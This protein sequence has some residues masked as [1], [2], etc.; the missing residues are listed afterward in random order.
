LE[1]QMSFEAMTWAVKQ[2]TANA[3]QKLVLL[4]LANHA[5]GH[6]GQCNPSQGLLATECCMGLSTLRRHL[7]DLEHDGHIRIVHKFAENMKRPSQYYLNI[8]SQN[9]AIDHPNWMDPPS[10]SDVPLPPNRMIEPGIKT[11]NKTNTVVVQKNNYFDDFWKAYPRKTNKGFAKKVFEKLK[12]DDAMLTKMIQAI[13]A[14]NKTV[15][16]D[17]D[18]Q[19]IPHPSTWLNGERWEDEIVVKQM[20]ASDREKAR[21]F[22]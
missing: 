3:G 22:G 5:N 12:V 16:K 11:S 20:S 1:K 15:W 7:I 14:Q 8:G 6:T 18:Q 9:R 2:T 13:H 4:L 17:K 10:E 21:I 19:Y